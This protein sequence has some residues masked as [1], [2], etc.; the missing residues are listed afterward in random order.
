M[1]V[2]LSNRHFIIHRRLGIQL[3]RT[4]QGRFFLSYTMTIL[5][6]LKV[7]T[8]HSA[9]FVCFNFQL[10]RR[11][12]ERCILPSAIKYLFTSTFFFCQIG[13]KDSSGIRFYY[14]SH[15]REYDAG[16]ICV[17]ERISKFA[18]IPPKQ[19]SWLTVGYCPKECYLV[20]CLKRSQSLAFPWKLLIHPHAIQSF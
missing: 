6:Q 10:R 16:I 19:E 1:Y 8:S 7:S 3:I 9:S 20:N 4:R 2:L 14:T 17:G 18:I 15:L 12:N 13:R 11:N 5:M